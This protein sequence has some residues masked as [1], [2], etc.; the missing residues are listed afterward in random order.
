MTT[1][2]CANLTGIFIL[3]MVAVLSLTTVAKAQ[4]RH[5]LRVATYTLTDLGANG[6]DSTWSFAQGINNSGEAVGEFVVW[7]GGI[8]IQHGFRTMPNQ[9]FMPGTRDD[10]GT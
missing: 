9:A 6:G 5:L 1:K 8:Q 10:L 4:R 2:R 7:S 3:A